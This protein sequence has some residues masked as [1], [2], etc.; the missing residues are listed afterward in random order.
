MK[1]RAIP[2]S[3][4]NAVV[5]LMKPY[6]HELTETRLVHAMQAYDPENADRRRPLRFLSTREVADIMQ[7]STFTVYR[8]IKRGEL[9]AAR[10]GGHWRIPGDV[11]EELA[12]GGHAFPD[13]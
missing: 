1:V 5:M 8:M 12:G 11:L 6:C 13:K 2:A 10:F 7:V 3:V 4:L 9:R